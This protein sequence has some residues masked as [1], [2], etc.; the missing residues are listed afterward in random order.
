MATR[1][2]PMNVVAE[3]RPATG[4]AL[5]SAARIARVAP[6]RR[7]ALRVAALGNRGAVHA[8]NMTVVF[9]A[10]RLAPRALLRPAGVAV[11]APARRPARDL[12]RRRR[13]RGR[14]RW[15]RCLARWIRRRRRRWTR[16]KAWWEGRR[17]RRRRRRECLDPEHGVRGAC[18]AAFVAKED[19]ICIVWRLAPRR[20]DVLAAIAAPTT[21][22]VEAHAITD[23]D[24]HIA[25]PARGLKRGGVSWDALIERGSPFRVAIG[26]RAAAAS[27]R[28]V[29][30]RTGVDARNGLRAVEFDV[31]EW[32]VGAVVRGGAVLAIAVGVGIVDRPARG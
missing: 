7:P 12:R 22:L 19:V 20:A 32:V 21:H 17:G 26:G 6:A 23:V 13:G 4:R 28:T 10:C 24:V 9:I 31:K 2:T 27:C 25:I 14:R 3:P 15:R 5:L 1:R 11:V 30:R 29:K 16:S 18:A 8:G